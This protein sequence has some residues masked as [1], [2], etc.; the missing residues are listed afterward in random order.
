MVRN[1]VFCPEARYSPQKQP[2][3]KVVKVVIDKPAFCGE[4]FGH[5]LSN[6][7]PTIAASEIKCGIFIYCERRAIGDRQKQPHPSRC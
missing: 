5:R 6:V 3:T 1:R 4:V 2:K 7:S